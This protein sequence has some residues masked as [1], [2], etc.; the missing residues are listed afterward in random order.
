MSGPDVSRYL[1]ASGGINIPPGTILTTAEAKALA[2]RIRNP[3]LRK[4]F[5]TQL[6]ACKH[7]PELAPREPVHREVEV[8]PFAFSALHPPHIKPALCEAVTELSSQMQRRLVFLLRRAKPGAPRL[9]RHV[10]QAEPGRPGGKRRTLHSLGELGA[11]APVCALFSIRL[12]THLWEISY[13][14]SSGCAGDAVGGPPRSRYVL[15]SSR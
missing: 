14:S 11:A 9:V 1:T 13:R 15:R 2:K 4:R 5:L 8:S 12:V 7:Y 3:V 10:T 6:M